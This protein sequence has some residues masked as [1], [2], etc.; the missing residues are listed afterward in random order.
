MQ[1]WRPLVA[2][3]LRPL[4]QDFYDVSTDLSVGDR[5]RKADIVRVPHGPGALRGLLA[6]LTPWN[7]LEFKGPTDDPALAI[8]S[9]PEVGPG[10][11][12]RLNEDRRKQGQG[13]WIATRCR[14][15]FWPTTSAAAFGRRPNACSAPRRVVVTNQCVDAHNC[16]NGTVEVLFNKGA[17]TF[18]AARS[19]FSGGYIPESVTVGDV[20]GDGKSDLVIANYCASLNNCGGGGCGGGAVG[21]LLGNGDGT[22]KSAL[23]Y[24]SGG[25]ETGFVAIKDVN[26]DGKPDIIVAKGSVGVMLGNGDGTFQPEVTYNGGYGAMSVAVADV[27]G[28]GKPDLLVANQSVLSSSPNDG[29]IG[30]LLGNGNGTFQPVTSY[31]SGGVNAIFVAVAD[32][33]GDGKLDL[34]AANRCVSNTSRCDGSYTGGGSVGVLLGNG[35]GTFQGGTRSPLLEHPTARSRSLTLMATAK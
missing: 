20:N 13:S 35:D 3:L 12:R 25:C 30:V 14:G 33:N 7:V 6:T 24:D 28:D 4:V 8:S 26:G 31:D 11:D 22:F 27:N 23:T 18:D 5:P 9:L 34:L 15:G 29:T 19:Y 16:N 21:V 2:F 1:Q 10:I 17:G 32:V